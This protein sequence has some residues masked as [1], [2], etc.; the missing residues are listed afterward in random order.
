MKRV[1]SGIQPSGVLHIGNYL[2]ALQHFVKRQDDHQ[3]FYCIVDLHALTM[4]QDPGALRELVQRLAATYLAVGLDPQKATLFIQSHVSA[5]SELGWLLQCVSY[6]GELNRMTQFKEK[7]D[8]RD[9]VSVGL[10]TYPVLQ[11]AD[12]LL[13]DTDYVPVGE[14]QKQHI[15]LCRDIAIRFNQRFGKV[16]TVPEHQIPKFGARIMSL[17]DPARKMSKSNENAGSYVSLVDTPDI[18]RKKIM[19]AVTDTGKEVRYDP[20][21]KAGVS[22]L[23]VIN[24]LCS[25]RTIAELESHFEGKGYGDLKKDTAEAVIA[26]VSPIRER[27][28]EIL[29]SGQ[30]NDL[31][32]EGAE[33]ARDV[34]DRTLDRVRQAMG[35]R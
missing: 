18:I 8:G 17:D 21:N 14:D 10:Y 34:A 3:S 4:P 33:R 20:E 35:V 23:L 24:S 1:F 15:E 2:G 27:T 13:Y 19:R 31:L 6:M 28:E 12:I 5:H 9:S 30:L 25:E 29:S 22:N 7:S 11:A 32:A 16:F 26:T